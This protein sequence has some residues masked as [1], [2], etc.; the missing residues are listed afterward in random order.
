MSQGR[1]GC[2]RIVFLLYAASLGESVWGGSISL[3]SENDSRLLK[4]NHNTD[5][6]YTSG[7]KL[8]YGF[9]PDWQW[10]ED[11]GHWDFPFF[12]ADSQEVATAAGL[13]LGQ[14]IYTPDYISLPFK[15]RPE[16]M[17]YAGWLYTGLFIQRATDEVMDQV[18]LSVGVIGPASRAQ[19]SQ[20]CIHNL[21]N[22]D[23]AIGW[24]DQINDEAAVNLD[25][26]RK[27]RLGGGHENLDFIAE[28][29]IAAGS[30][31]CNAQVGLMGRWSL[32]GELPRDFGPGRFAVP[33][34][35]LGRSASMPT[36]AYLFSRVS[37]K[38]VGYNR[39]LSGL[40]TRPLTGELQVGIA[41]QYKSMEASYSQTF[42][43][44]EYEEQYAVDGYGSFALSWHF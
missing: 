42:L 40:D 29:G 14:H 39:F 6:H 7:T 15:R 24:D 31:H 1:T 30:V 8:V 3:Y 4:P 9:Q 19:Q 44:H 41:V 16:D 32:L 38:A 12:P 2:L 43:T 22:S 17:K 18:Q 27:Q 11:F 21:F 35:V 13:F 34:G 37:G 20:S 10:L 5:R 23:K 26:M 33:S 25:W 28:Y 36:A